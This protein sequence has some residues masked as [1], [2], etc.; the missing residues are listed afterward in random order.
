MR[1]KKRKLKAEKNQL[2]D[3]VEE[4]VQ[5]QQEDQQIRQRLED[6]LKEAEGQK[7]AL[8]GERDQLKRDKD[9]LEDLMRQAQGNIRQM[10]EEKEH[11]SA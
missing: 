2:L 6:S 4:S 8:T 7:L 5:K 10:R 3:F 11:L 9:N 1:E